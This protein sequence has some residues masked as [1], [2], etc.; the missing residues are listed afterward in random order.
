MEEHPD[1][2]RV[3]NV[4]HNNHVGILSTILIGN[5]LVNITASALATEVAARYFLDAAIPIAI[6]VTTFVL[7]FA[8]EITPKTLARAYSEQLAIPCMY[9]VLV[10]HGVFYPVSWVLTN[11]IRIMIT[12]MGGRIKQSE[13]VTE[14]DIEYILTLGR[15]QGSLDRER[16]TLLSSVFEFTDT[17]AREI[18]VP[19]TEMVAV[20][21]DS[22]YE[23]VVEVAVESGYSRIPV[24]DESIDKIVGVFYAKDLITPPAE[25]EKVGFLRARMRSPAFIPRTAKI[26]QVFR[27]FQ[28]EHI[29]M[30]I[31]VDEFGGT[32]GIVT[33]ED[34]IEELFG[35]IQ[36]E[37]DTEEER[38]ETLPDGKHLVDAR[39]DI[40]EVE[41]LLSIDF[42]EERDYES[43]GGYL[44]A[45][46]GEV[47]AVGWK[48]E[49]R[50]YVFTVTQAD[51]NRVIRIEVD[52]VRPQ[53]KGDAPESKTD[54][55]TAPP[56][57]NTTE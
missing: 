55:G 29:H 3:L 21:L 39:I 33:M 53:E 31:V 36:D 30:A 51:V 25:A 40:E 35:E 41:E 42:P 19:R 17:I 12:M 1:L 54:G 6:G 15:R 46:A 4:W 13:T 22:P 10:F 44:M 32:E 48:K 18:M 49:Y 7:L 8:G 26:S 27:L 57:R 56:A 2:G 16:E 11:G 24:Y 9:L 37:F 45:Q 20:P 5:T 14:D 43:L 34:I 28:T 52:Q 50:G 23:K 38:F 47:P